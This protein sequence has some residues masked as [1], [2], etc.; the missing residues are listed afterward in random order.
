MK[1]D[2]SRLLDCLAAGYRLDLDHA[3]YVKQLVDLAVPLLDVGLGVIGYT[4]DATNPGNPVIDTFVNSDLFDPAWLPPFYESLAK[5]QVDVPRSDHPTGFQAWG[6]M[7]CGQASQIEGMRDIL[8]HFRHIG[9]STDSFAV[10]AL[11]A[12]G[13]GLWLG[14]PLPTTKKIPDARVTLFTRFA[15]HLTSAYRIR[16]T[17]GPKPPPRA[18]VMSPRGKLLHAEGDSIAGARD[19]L[20]DATLAFDHA[21]TRKMRDDVELATRTWKPLIESRWALLDEF[22]TDGK[23]FVVAV[24]NAPPTRARTKELSE[25]ELQVL[26]AAHFGHSNKVIAYELGLAASTVRV[27]LHRAAQKLGA[28]TREQAIS[29]FDEVLKNSK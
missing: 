1:H 7:R 14:A 18:A 25:R 17:H 10:N 15:S 4:Y 8:P 9:G 11:D 29:R 27:L 21:R 26:T 2:V 19:E 23:R 3:S 20:R 6:S 12:S 28:K 24:E 5:A 16:R 13:R 22:D